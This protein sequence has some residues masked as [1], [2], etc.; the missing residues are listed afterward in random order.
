MSATTPARDTGTHVNSSVR[1]H[2]TREFPP[3]A[4]AVRAARAFVTESALCDG[5]D[6]E[7]LALAVSELATNVILH[8]NTPF[9]VTVERLSDGV[10]VGITDDNPTEPRIRDIGSATIT[11]RGL[12][13]VRSLSRYLH[14]EATGPGKTVWFELGWAR[15]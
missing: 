6:A 7:A 13:I 11:G 4:V 2:S 5:V 12:A 1:G 15:P 14:V 8:A 9:I 3:E 10:R